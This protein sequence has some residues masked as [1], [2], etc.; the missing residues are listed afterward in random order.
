MITITDLSQDTPLNKTVN[1]R[2]VAL[3]KSLTNC[4]CLLTTGTFTGTPKLTASLDGINFYPLHNEEGNQI[5]LESGKIIFLNFLNLFL[6]VDLTGVS[7]ND[8][9]V[10]LQ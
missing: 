6:K 10:S 1:L 5:E 4:L 8:L 2:E 3:H 7:S 9:K